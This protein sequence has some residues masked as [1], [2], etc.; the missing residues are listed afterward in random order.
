MSYIF[1]ALQ[2]SYSSTSIT[3][4]RN[5]EEILTLG[6]E[7]IRASSQLVPELDQLLKKTGHT[8]SDIQ[9]MAVEQGP[10]AFTSLRVAITTANAIG[11]ATN[12]PLVGIDGLHALAHEAAQSLCPSETTHIVPILNAYNDE[13]YYGIYPLIGTEC[14]QALEHGYEKVSALR[15]KLV[16][17]PAIKPFVL[18][19]GTIL[20]HEFFKQA[21]GENQVLTNKKHMQSSIQNI[22]RMGLAAWK[23]NHEQGEKKLTPL[24]LKTQTFATR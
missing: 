14:G 10:G 13:V 4:F 24:Y 22:A 19:N 2:G 21:F 9:F 3:L 18:G 5:N 16:S 15:Q 1:L 20:H 7:S 6:G 23:S 17:Q 8:L 12:I 11:F